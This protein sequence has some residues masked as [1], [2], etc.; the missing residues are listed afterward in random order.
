MIGTYQQGQPKRSSQCKGDTLEFV[1]KAELDRAL[2]EV[3]RLREKNE[4]LQRENERL[5]KELEEA[6]RA[7]KR[8]TAPFSRRKPKAK[9][10]PTGR[11]SGWAHGK[12]P[13]RT[14]PVSGDERNVAPLPA[15]CGWRGPPAKAS[16]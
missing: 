3:E 13:R 16:I 15:R 12:H 1:A 4:G 2:E 5:Q 11:K 6:R 7:L 10:R 8:Q 14:G 9:R